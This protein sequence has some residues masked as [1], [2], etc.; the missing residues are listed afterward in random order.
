MDNTEAPVSLAPCPSKPN[1]V[2]SYATSPRQ[3][4][5]PLTYAGSHIPAMSRLESL[6]RSLPRVKIITSD[7]VYLHAEFR[8]ALLGFVDDV[9]FLADTGAN[10]IHVRS[11]SRVGYSDFGVNRRRVEG[12][13]SKFQAG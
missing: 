6:L 10:V 4:V 12:I 5:E 9:E 1:C 3:R 13:R 8:S 7:G 2:S 11:A